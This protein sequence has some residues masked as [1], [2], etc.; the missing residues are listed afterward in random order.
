MLRCNGT[1]AVTARLPISRTRSAHRTAHR[2]FIAPRSRGAQHGTYACTDRRFWA[3]ALSRRS[4]AQIRSSGAPGQTVR[5]RSAV[6]PIA[7][8]IAAKPTPVTRM[9]LRP[10]LSRSRSRA[11]PPTN[12]NRA[13]KKTKTP[14]RTNS[15]P[16]TTRRRSVLARFV[17]SQVCEKRGDDA[18]RLCYLP[19]PLLT[20][21]VGPVRIFGPPAP[22]STA[23]PHRP[24]SSGLRTRVRPRCGEAPR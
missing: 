7:I 5:I 20:I 12:K 13:P 4:P 15:T 21:R 1:Q 18:R 8:P 6:A 14:P 22:M 11:R 19:G 24:S 2:A 23:R 17:T 10:P 16:A 9:T 3:H